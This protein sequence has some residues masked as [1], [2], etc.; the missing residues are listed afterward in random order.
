[1]RPWRFVELGR[2][3]DFLLAGLGWCRMPAT[4]IAPYLANGRL[5]VLEID[6]D[7]ARVHGPLTI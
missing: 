6:D 1:M 3:L 2:R 4:L 7:P 5:M